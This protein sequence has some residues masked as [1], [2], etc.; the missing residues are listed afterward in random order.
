MVLRDDP[1]DPLRTAARQMIGVFAE[2]ERGMIRLRLWQGQLAK[3]A[4]GLNGGGAYQFG[5]GRG[6]EDPREQRVLSYARRRRFQGASWRQIAEAL[7]ARGRE[8]A[9]RRGGCWTA[10]GARQSLRDREPPSVR[11][12][13]YAANPPPPR[14]YEQGVRRKRRDP[15][16]QMIRAVEVAR[17]LGVS[18]K[19]VACQVRRGWIPYT[20]DEYGGRWFDPVEIGRLAQRE[21]DFAENWIRL[22]KLSVFFHMKDRRLRRWA[23]AGKIPVAVERHGHYLVPIEPVLDTPPDRI[24]LLQPQA[25]AML[26]SNRRAT[27]F[28]DTS[29]WSYATLI[30]TGQQIS[31]LPVEPRWTGQHIEWAGQLRLLPGS[32]EASGQTAVVRRV[33]RHSEPRSGRIMTFTVLWT[34]RGVLMCGPNKRILLDDAAGAGQTCSVRHVDTDGGRRRGVGNISTVHIL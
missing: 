2:L 16:P 20:R 28:A 25:P 9:T 31:V 23:H 15:P 17:I 5:W 3:K 21:V 34:G 27:A 19:I 10:Q 8:F 24:V 22:G 33:S 13:R 26:G 7:N 30:H 29:R 4:L 12:K 32:G 18:P 1:S 6:G 14:T 11:Y